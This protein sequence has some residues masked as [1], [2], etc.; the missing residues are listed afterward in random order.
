MMK[1]DCAPLDQILSAEVPTYIKLDIEGAEMD[2][3][4]GAAGL[5]RQH[6]PVLAVSVYHQQD[7]LWRIPLYLKTLFPGYQ[8]FLRP[9]NEEAWDLICYAIPEE[10]V[11]C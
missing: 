8:F 10:R 4:K 9:H 7:H 1:V 6:K 3:L 2:A 11:V 5:I